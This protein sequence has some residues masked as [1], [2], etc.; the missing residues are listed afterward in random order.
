MSDTAMPASMDAC[1][2]QSNKCQEACC[3]HFGQGKVVI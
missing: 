1:R 3:E 2:T